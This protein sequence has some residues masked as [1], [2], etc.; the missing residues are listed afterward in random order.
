MAPTPIAGTPVSG[1]G[2]TVTGP[3]PAPTGAIAITP[4]SGLDGSA[5][6]R[7]LVGQ[8]EPHRL[9]SLFH[10]LVVLSAIGLSLARRKLPHY[11]PVLRSFLGTHQL[12]AV[13]G[14]GN[15]GIDTD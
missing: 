7:R 5:V 9:G 2:T 11:H 3:P 4:I 14:L 8:R 12:A 10:G 13:V 6:G 1:T 15:G